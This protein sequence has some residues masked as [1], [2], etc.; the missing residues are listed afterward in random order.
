M[1]D[2]QLPMFVLQFEK[3]HAVGLKVGLKGISDV[4]CIDFR[5]FIGFQGDMKST[6]F[7]YFRVF[8][9]Q[10]VDDWLVNAE[11]IFE[12]HLRRED[13]LNAL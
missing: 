4:I 3:K 7:H 2:F 1:V 9:E 12:H 13:Q 11:E 6:L 8:V 5:Q 10:I